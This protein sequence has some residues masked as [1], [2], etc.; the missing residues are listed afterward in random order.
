M[1]YLHAYY[2]TR[3]ITKYYRKIKRSNQL[4]NEEMLIREIL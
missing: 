4:K 2:H 1:Y 3:C